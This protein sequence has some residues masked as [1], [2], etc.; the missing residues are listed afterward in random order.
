MRTIESIRK[1]QTLARQDFTSLLGTVP[2]LTRKN[3]QSYVV[4]L[5]FI[6]FANGRKPLA[7]G[8]G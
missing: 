1:S 5:K 7:T 3:K 6:D 8:Q 4:L 2:R